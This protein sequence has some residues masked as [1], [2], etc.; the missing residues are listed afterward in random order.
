MFQSQQ[1]TLILTRGAIW[2]YIIHAF[3]QF[4]KKQPKMSLR[5]NT[6]KKIEVYLTLYRRKKCLPYLH[7]QLRLLESGKAVRTRNSSNFQMDVSWSTDGLT[8]SCIEVGD[9]L[10]ETIYAGTVEISEEAL[11]DTIH[12]LAEEFRSY[13]LIERN[14]RHFA[15][16]L[17]MRLDPNQKTAAKNRLSDLLMMCKWAAYFKLKAI[18]FATKIMLT[19]GLTYLNWI[20]TIVAERFLTLIS[21]CSLALLNSY[22]EYIT[23]M[24]HLYHQKKMFKLPLVDTDFHFHSL[25]NS[26]ENL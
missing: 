19:R 4:C 17:L 8:T 13:S 1:L 3:S 14:C 24:I 5:Q 23:G 21:M 12:V 11:L 7:A 2:F 6:T 16:Q 25:T 26:L 9:C 18:D 10:V 15:L 22:N 20:I